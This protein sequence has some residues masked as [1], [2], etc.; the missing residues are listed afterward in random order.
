[1]RYREGAV[2]ASR[3]LVF[4]GF[5]WIGFWDRG[6]VERDLAYGDHPRQTLDIYRPSLGQLPISVVFLHGG[7]WQTGEKSEYEF[8]GRAFARAGVACAVVNYRLYP[9]VR[10]PGFVE[11][12]AQAIAWLGY[13]GT[14]YGFDA[15]NM[16][17]VGHSAGAHIACLVAMDPDYQQCFG[18]SPKSIRSLVGLS[19]AYKFRPE[20]SSTFRDLFVVDADND[21]RNC[22]P[23]SF[24]R[25][26]GVPLLLIH[27][28]NDATVACRSAERMYK[29]AVN[30]GHPC[31][32]KVYEQYGHAG[33]LLDLLPIRQNHSVM[34]NDIIEFAQKYSL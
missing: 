22:K 30:A 14:Q 23:V 8:V 17:L 34:M 18:F 3:K 11:D 29:E 13:H 32:L 12:V 21:Y 10:F 28:R 7:H 5:R 19:G 27:G 15:D 6:P 20:R 2:E 33:T 26:D 25:P 9:D 31:V 4:W 24:V 16:C 1:M